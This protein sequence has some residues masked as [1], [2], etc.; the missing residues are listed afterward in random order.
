M[1]FIKHLVCSQFIVNEV[2][3]SLGIRQHTYCTCR[4]LL[5]PNQRVNIG[6]RIRKS[7]FGKRFL[8]PS[9]T[10]F[11]YCFLTSC[12][13]RVCSTLHKMTKTGGIKQI[14]VLSKDSRDRQAAMQ[15]WQAVKP[16]HGR[17]ATSM[18]QVPAHG[19]MVPVHST[20]VDAARRP[21]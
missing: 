3:S 20:W 2:E 1:A 6:Y 9:G 19:Y 13:Q 12:A 5:D 8:R 14:H 16:H 18:G 21:A 7:A 17:P 15:A 10:I 11:S 4:C